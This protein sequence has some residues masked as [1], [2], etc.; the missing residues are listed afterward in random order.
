MKSLMMVLAIIFAF[1]TLVQSAPLFP[2]AAA[3]RENSGMPE[4]LNSRLSFCQT[5]K[6]QAAFKG[7]DNKQYYFRDHDIF[8]VNNNQ[9]S[10]THRKT[11]FT[12]SPYFVDA[13]TYSQR[14]GKAYLFKNRQVWIYKYR[15]NKFTHLQTK[16]LDRIVPNILDSAFFYQGFIY[17]LKDGYLY[18]WDED[19]NTVIPNHVFSISYFW[20]D[21]PE[22]IDAVM[23]GE[24]SKETVF[25][26]WQPVYKMQYYLFDNIARKMVTSGSFASFFPFCSS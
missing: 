19:R 25:W 10:S 20:K 13:M 6:F 18:A 9:V 5:N 14:T 22:K 16:R 8:V 17:L 23:Q 2:N 12:N 4:S 7:P 3:L 26:K 1:L 24:N 15:G 21:V 11:V